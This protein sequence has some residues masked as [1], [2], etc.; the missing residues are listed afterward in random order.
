M[1]PLNIISYMAEHYFTAAPTAAAQER[2]VRYC[3]RDFDYAVTASDGTFSA[4]GLD[5]GTAV[6]LAK[7]PRAELAA[8]GV[9]EQGGE[10]TPL[11]VDVGCGWGPIALALAREYPQ[12]RVL[13]V[14]VNE[15]AMDLARRNATALRLENLQIKP[16]D[17]AAV[18]IRERG[19]KIDL[20]WSNP[21]IRIGKEQLHELLVAWLDL[22]SPQGAAYWVVQKNLGADSLTAWLNEQGYP[23]EKVASQKGFRLIRSSRE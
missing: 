10:R 1:P 12:A 21:P 16:A 17:E 20:I 11:L 23:S 8:G 13:G 3:A 4:H 2:T 7:A 9:T 5:K 22:L 18:E 6:L 15:R 14:D 19:E